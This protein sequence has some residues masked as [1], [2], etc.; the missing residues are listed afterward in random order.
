MNEDAAR[1]FDVSVV[2]AVESCAE[3]CADDLLHALA[4]H[5][6]AAPLS[7][8]RRALIERTTS[9]LLRIIADE[10]QR[11]REPGEE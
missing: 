5:P 2:R 1:R 9:A 4:A 6:F 3:R 11:A 10:S 8:R 7:A